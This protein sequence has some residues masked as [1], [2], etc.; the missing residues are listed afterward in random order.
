MVHNR[1]FY[2]LEFVVA[3]LLMSLAFIEEPSVLGANLETYV[4]GILELI[5]LGIISIESVMKCRWMSPK[6]FVRHKRSMFKVN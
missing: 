1:T 3:I 6:V 4:H 2:T 5:F